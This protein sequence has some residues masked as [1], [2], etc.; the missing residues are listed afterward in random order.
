MSGAF[1]DLVRERRLIAI[2]RHVPDRY[3]VEL[4][5]VIASA[6][7]DLIE[8][9]LVDEGAVRQIG[10]L[11]ESLDDAAHIGA[12]TVVR[13]SQARAAHEAGAGYL[14]TPH[15]QEEVAAYAREHGLGLMLGAMTPT[16]IERARALGSDLVKVF[17]AST[18]GPAF[19]KSIRGPFPEAPLVAVGGVG[20]SNLAEYLAAGAVAAGIGSSLTSLDW[21]APDFGRI[22]AEA[23][24]L[25]ETA[26]QSGVP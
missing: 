1:V 14:I 8:V 19:F 7:I 12:G 13:A 20:R 6:G 5:R 17:P 9:S 22:E 11:S 16:E 26:H 4:A 15:V 24:A 2:F 25:V 23:R 3:V 18:V 21:S 10:A